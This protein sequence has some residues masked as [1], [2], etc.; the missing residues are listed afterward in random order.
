MDR[1]Y[2]LPPEGKRN[3]F[4]SIPQ[5]SGFRTL[6]LA[7]IHALLNRLHSAP[8]FVAN[9]P[10]DFDARTCTLTGKYMYD[11]LAYP[12]NEAWSN[13]EWSATIQGENFRPIQL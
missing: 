6:P 3:L 11:F 1:G 9:S 8:L 2:T 10:C 7:H 4:E 5:G 13:G 12:G